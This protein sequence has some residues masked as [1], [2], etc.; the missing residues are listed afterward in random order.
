M[1]NGQIERDIAAVFFDGENLNGAIE[2]LLKAGIAKENLSLLCTEQ[3]VKERLQADYSC[4]A[5]I[6]DDG[7]VVRYVENEGTAST[8]SS[9]IGGLSLAA[10]AAGGGA[11]IASAGIFGG[12]VAV[13]TAASVVVGGVGA[14]ASAFI[15]Q[16]DADAL[17]SE[18][19][20]GH[21]VLLVRT[22][23]DRVK[24]EVIALLGDHSGLDARVLQ[25]A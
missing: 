2:A 11:I 16:S 4:V 9:T 15:S 21:I 8:V 13:A 19:D 6:E 17:Q 22:G 3:A 5:A 12:A 23:E 25:A 10:T 1:T 24:D 18:L 7:S 14:L 20:A